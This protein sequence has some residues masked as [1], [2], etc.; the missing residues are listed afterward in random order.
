[1]PAHGGR[2]EDWQ[3]LGERG[4]GWATH[5]LT[6]SL[7]FC[8]GEILA[9]QRTLSPSLILHQ[10]CPL[11]PTWGWEGVAQL[12]VEQMPAV[13][14]VLLRGVG[15]EEGED[16]CR[17]RTGLGQ[18]SL[19]L[20]LPCPVCGRVTDNGPTLRSATQASSCLGNLGRK[21]PHLTL[22]LPMGRG[23][24]GSCR[25]APEV[26]DSPGSKGD[27]DHLTQD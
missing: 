18:L 20:W 19:P 23:S 26:G 24:A 27:K 3:V 9:P 4:Q 14:L 11:A 25:G 7:P 13:A 8:G 12:T 6:H 17:P 15:G 21:S 5:S 22:E 16:S 1:M 2:G 10:P